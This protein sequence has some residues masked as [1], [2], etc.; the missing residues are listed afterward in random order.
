MKAQNKKPS[1]SLE[2]DHEKGSEKKGSENGQERHK[3]KN[4]KAR[5]PPSCHPYQY[6][7]NNMISDYVHI[8]QLKTYSGQ[9]ND[10]KPGH[11]GYSVK[12]SEFIHQ[13]NL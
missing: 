10:F 4:F 3:L 12:R 9:L 1:F 7:V 5:M 8:E 13:V 11:A 6:P 2:N